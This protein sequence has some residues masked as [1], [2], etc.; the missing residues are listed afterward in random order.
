MRFTASQMVAHYSGNFDICFKNPSNCQLFKIS[1]K[2]S[3]FN[4]WIVSGKNFKV[5][6]SVVYSVGMTKDFEHFLVIISTTPLDTALTSPNFRER[7]ATE[8]LIG[9]PNVKEINPQEGWLEVT[10]VKQCEEKYK[11]NGAIFRNTYLTNYWANFLQ[12]WY[13]MQS[14]IYGG[15]KIFEFD[16]N[17]PT[18][19]LVLEI[20]GVEIYIYI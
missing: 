5:I 19:Y 6:R 9:V 2:W 16:R 8:Y 14:H 18:D 4:K 20:P 1:S 3:T 12:I 15:D 17:R 11:E 13:G 10:F 7:Q